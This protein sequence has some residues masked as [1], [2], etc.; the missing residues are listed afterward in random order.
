MK[1]LKILRMADKYLSAF[2]RVLLR[3]NEKYM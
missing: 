1:M 3:F 2:E